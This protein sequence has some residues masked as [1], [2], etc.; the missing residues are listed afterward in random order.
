MAASTR[1]R[2]SSRA[3]AS[4][5]RIAW[6]LARRAAIS[7]CTSAARLAGARRGSLQRQSR[8]RTT[9]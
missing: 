9:K 6:P 2:A 5:R 3:A 7:A 8:P 4:P 1:A